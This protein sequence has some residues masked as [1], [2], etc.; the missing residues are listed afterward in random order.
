MAFLFIK[1]FNA[2]YVEV[3][4]SHPGLATPE[5]IIKMVQIA[6]VWQTGIR[7]GV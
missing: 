5:T 4:G 3:V 7:V 2:S 6:P 1:S